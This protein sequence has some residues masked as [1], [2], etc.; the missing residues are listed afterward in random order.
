VAEIVP[1]AVA[2]AGQEKVNPAALLLDAYLDEVMTLLAENPTPSE[3][4]VHGVLQHRW[5]ERDGTYADLVARRSQALANLPG[6]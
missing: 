2:T 4:L 5:A 1:P 6:H 3:I